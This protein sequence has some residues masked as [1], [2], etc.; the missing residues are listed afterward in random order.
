MCFR[1]SSNAHCLGQ[2]T[3]DPSGPIVAG[4]IGTWTLRLTVGSYGI[5]EGGTIKAARRFASDWQT[6]QFDRLH[7][8]AYTTVRAVTES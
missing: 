4:R 1:A 7:E 2:V 3:L 6:P 8:P 5:D